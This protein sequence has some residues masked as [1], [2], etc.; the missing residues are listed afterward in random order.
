MK[1]NEN[2]DK[3]N[4]NI[5]FNNN[6]F[7]FFNGLII[8]YSINIPLKDDIRSYRSRNWIYYLSSIWKRMKY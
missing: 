8:R 5:R 4:I 1:M 2:F 7:L 6:I 3:P